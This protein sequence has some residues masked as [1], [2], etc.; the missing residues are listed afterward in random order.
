LWHGVVLA[1]SA[2]ILEDPG[3]IT[4]QTWGGFHKAVCDLKICALGLYFSLIY[5]QVFAP[6]AQLIVFSPRFGYA[7]CFTPCAQLL[8]NPTLLSFSFHLQNFIFRSRRM[9]RTILQT[10]N[11]SC[12]AFKKFVTNQTAE[13]KINEQKPCIF[14]PLVKRDIYN[15]KIPFWCC[16]KNVEIFYH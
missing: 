16:K 13:P 10:I 7:L 1:D 11:Y 3:F 12:L 14:N 2:A 15:F 8:W 5:Y 4:T 6:Y 9:Q